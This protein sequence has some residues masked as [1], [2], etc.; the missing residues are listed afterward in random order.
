MTRFDQVFRWRLREQ[1]HGRRQNQRGLDPFAAH[2]A[3]LLHRTD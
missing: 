3:V 2:D 1:R